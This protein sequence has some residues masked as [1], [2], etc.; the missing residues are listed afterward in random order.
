LW[1][2]IEKFSGGKTEYNAATLQSLLGDKW[3]TATEHLMAVGFF[4]KY[5]K[6]GQAL[7][8]IP[9][10]YRHGMQLTQGRA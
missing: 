3:Q 2:D 8:S 9:F 5:E 4:S 1:T 7:F 6:D 10:L